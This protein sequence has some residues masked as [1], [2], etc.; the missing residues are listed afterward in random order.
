MLKRSKISYAAASENNANESSVFGQMQRV[1]SCLRGVSK[2][3]SW[4]PHRR[5]QFHISVGRQ[6]RWETDTKP[7]FFCSRRPKCGVLGAKTEAF[8]G[9]LFTNVLVGRHSA[10]SCIYLNTIVLSLQTSRG[11]TRESGVFRGK[12]WV[13]RVFF[14]VLIDAGGGLAYS[15]Y[16]TFDG[17]CLQKPME[18]VPCVARSAGSIAISGCR[19]IS[20]RVLWAGTLRGLFSGANRRSACRT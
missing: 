2:L 12:E 19:Q 3:A 16:A 14:R 5:R 9:L 1:G 20:I 7:P 10:L 4:R 17:N 18:R 13:F 15:H 6:R 11:N 8:R